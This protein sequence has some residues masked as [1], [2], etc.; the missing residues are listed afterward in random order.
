MRAGIRLAFASVLLTTVVLL[1]FVG[2]AKAQDIDCMEC[3]EEVVFDSPA[4]PDVACHECHTNVGPEHE[5]ADLEPLTDE[6]SCVECHSRTQ[7]EIGRSAHNGEAGC[8]DCHG[9]PHEITEVA[10]LHSAVS[11]VGQIQN[12]GGCHDTEE[13]PLELYVASEHGRAV[14]LS[15]LDAAPGCSDC[16]GSHRVFAVDNDRSPTS[17]ENSPEMCGACHTLLL[18]DWKSMSAHGIAWQEGEEGVE[19][20]VCTDCHAT[21]DIVDPTTADSRMA[22]A[23][24]CGSCHEDYLGT[25]RHSF[26]GQATGLG[27]A[28]G[29]V[30]ADC[31]TPHKNLPASDP[32]SS[33]HPDNVLATCSQCHEG[34]S[35]NF[36]SFQPHIDP[37][38][39]DDHYPVYIVWLFMTSLLIGVFAFFG[40]HDLLWLQRSWV[41]LKRGEFE[42]EKVDT[43]QWVRRFNMTNVRTHALIITTFLLL[44]LTGLPLKFS[45]SPWAQT[46]MNLLGG[47]DMARALHRIAAIGT[48]GYMLF[49]VG[50]VAW[51]WIVKREK[52]MFWGP[53]SMMPQPKDVTDFA[54][55]IRWF[56]YMGERP[57]G[58]RWT[59]FEKFDYLAVFW[60]VAIIG[61]SGLALWFPLLFTTYLPGWTLNA[62]HVIHSDEALLATGFIFFFHFFH[63]HLRPESFP[64]DTVIFTG[65]MPL[66]RFKHERP[67]E[68]QRLVDSGELENYLVPPPRPR[69]LRRAYFWGTIA[70][71]TGIALAIGIIWALLSH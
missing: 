50:N 61:I 23:D 22:S 64:M 14:L 12:C 16:H 18:D 41:G 24:N 33:V 30:C 39:P 56:L 63:T 1:L 51:R 67:L 68:Y 6:E 29:A 31:H 54:A 70:L 49:H 58:D 40:I 59:Y 57:Q 20:P 26:H 37:T 47:V 17:R 28:D 43:G 69:Q 7:R 60:G 71:I 48:F 35:A 15:G 25:F 42:A 27:K 21:H 2:T 32:R 53:N 34:V 13:M 66:E 19:A 10:D 9:A 44:A 55:N 65:K 8:T 46:L 36:A 62:A 4:H 11:A 5:D 45:G 3:H 38:N 52:G